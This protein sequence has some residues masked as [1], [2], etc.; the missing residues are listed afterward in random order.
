MGLICD[1]YGHE[2]DLERFDPATLMAPCR[3][4]HDWKFYRLPR[5]GREDVPRGGWRD[6]PHDPGPEWDEGGEG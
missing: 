4:C 1:A 6:D 2:L 5:W 3:I